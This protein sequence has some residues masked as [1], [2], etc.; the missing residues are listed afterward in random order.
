MYTS[1]RNLSVPIHCRLST[2]TP[3]LTYLAT[4][5]SLVFTVRVCVRVCVGSYA[6]SCTSGANSSSCVC[7]V[8]MRA[9]VCIASAPPLPLPPPSLSPLRCQRHPREGTAPSSANHSPGAQ[10]HDCARTLAWVIIPVLYPFIKYP[11]SYSTQEVL[12]Q[13]PAC[14]MQQLVYA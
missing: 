11:F 4:S 5:S 6:A 9:C 14:A 3:A 10:G 13:P 12:T 8:W 1:T 2:F 7:G